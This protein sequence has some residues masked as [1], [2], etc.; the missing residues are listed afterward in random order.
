[1]ILAIEKQN[2]NYVKYNVL[3]LNRK[4][5]RAI[6]NFDTFCNQLKNMSNMS[7]TSIVSSSNK[8]VSF[9][10]QCIYF[11][12]MDRTKQ[13]Y[14]FYQNDIIITPHGA[15][16][17]NLLT[18][19]MFNTIFIEICPKYFH[20]Q[21]WTEF[22]PCKYW[23]YQNNAFVCICGMYSHA[24]FP[25]IKSV[26]YMFEI[27]NIS[28]KQACKYYNGNQRITRNSKYLD[29]IDVEKIFNIMF[30]YAINPLNFPPIANYNVTQFI[31]PIDSNID[32]SK[33][34]KPRKLTQF[35]V[36]PQ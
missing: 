36:Q 12:G 4:G 33:I 7:T 16:L 17:T 28:C 32:I 25:N 21:C 30:Q 3:V 34:N 29:K 19:R 23:K 14:K 31:H 11:E 24:T 26:T 18:A 6:Q 13:L 27:N 9:D 35:I 8:H 2:A 1:M 15:G 5:N 22:P 20:C 10:I